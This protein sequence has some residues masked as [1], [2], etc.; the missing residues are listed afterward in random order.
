[1]APLR[2]ITHF[3][4]GPT[5]EG[6]GSDFDTQCQSFDVTNESAAG[7]VISG[8]LAMQVPHATAERL[9]IRGAL[10]VL[11][12]FTVAS[13][14]KNTWK[15]RKSFF[16]RHLRCKQRAHGDARAGMTEALGGAVTLGHIASASAIFLGTYA[17]LCGGHYVMKIPSN[18]CGTETH[19]SCNGFFNELT[20]P[21]GFL[22]GPFI[23]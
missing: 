18:T 3:V 23:P 14:T 11:V 6:S 15:T 13:V 5:I 8:R 2:N 16:A 17:A 7:T 22:S 1:M 20:N 21:F 10:S 4:Y 19:I 12:L 9:Q